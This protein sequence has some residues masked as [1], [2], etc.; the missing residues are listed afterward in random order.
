MFEHI[1]FESIM[2]EML[3]TVPDNM[4]KREG[5]I[6]YNALAPAA[7]K[8]YEA[9]ISLA[10]VLVLMFP[11]TSE[12]EYLEMIVAEEGIRKNYATPSIR[13]FE[14]TGSS[15]QITEGDRFFVDNIYFVAQETID[16]PG[17]F[18]AQSEETGRETAI[19]N[20]QTILPVEDIE[21]LESISMIQHENDVDG[22]DDET[23]EAL[24]QRYW[25]R[26]R[27][28]PGPGNNADYIRWAK[29]VPGVGNVL[30]EPLWKGPGTIRLV[31]LTPDGKQAP[32]SLINEVQELIDPG[33]RGIG[34]GKAPPGAKVTVA[35]ADLLYVN[36]VIP[37]LVPEQ[38]YSME[39]V[40]LNATEA[41]NN[42][43]REINPGGVVRLREAESAIINAPGV[44]DM[45][46]LLINGKREN[47]QLDII[48]LVTLGEV[49]FS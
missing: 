43:L 4:D 12:G 21:G 14:A 37:G 33:S 47:L 28:S 1:S 41:L 22:L 39:Q 42:Y 46:D 30:P 8:F 6:I 36:V 24:L 15:G 9:Y 34:E 20:P 31:I 10:Q 49:S 19:Y 26:V 11:Q 27:S 40:Q 13:H 48:Q 45:G 23:D 18:K 3:D 17:V 44:L 5:S 32:Q 35:T 2:E 16:I 38:G 7:G 25:E 29:E